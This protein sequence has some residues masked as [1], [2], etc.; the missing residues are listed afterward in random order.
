M[1]E[2]YNKIG[3]SLRCSTLQG[4]TELHEFVLLRLHCLQQGGAM[5]SDLQI[6]FRMLTV[7]DFS[8]LRNSRY[9]SNELM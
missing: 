2:L 5:P 8:C 3:E 7:C 6:H 1:P 4:N 9:K